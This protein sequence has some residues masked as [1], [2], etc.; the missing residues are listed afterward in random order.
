[1][2]MICQAFSFDIIW[3]K[4]VHEKVQMAWWT[5]VEMKIKA[6]AVLINIWGLSCIAQQG[7]SFGRE[8]QIT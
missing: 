6:R 1:M 2:S 7:K 4:K 8:S 3:K 5:Q